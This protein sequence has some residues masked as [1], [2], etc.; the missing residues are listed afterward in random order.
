MFPITKFLSVYGRYKYCH[1][2]GFELK[3][4]GGIWRLH[5]RAKDLSHIDEESKIFFRKVGNQPTY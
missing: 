4:P 3:P 1:L 2:L 5:F